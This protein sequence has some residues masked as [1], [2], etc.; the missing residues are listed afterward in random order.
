MNYERFCRR[1]VYYIEMLDQIE[2]QVTGGALRI[3]YSAL[4]LITIATVWGC[5]DKGTDPKPVTIR[6]GMRYFPVEQGNK[7]F[8]NS[9]QY[10]R[11]LS[12]DTTIAG[13]LCQRLLENGETEE[14]W[15]LTSAR[16]AQHLLAGFLWFDPPLQIPLNLEKDKPHQ[17]TAL[18]KIAPGFTSSIDSARFAGTITFTGYSQ[19]DVA[20]VA[21]DSCIGLHYIIKSTIYFH[22][23]EADT[24]TDVYD[25]Y[26]ARGIGLV[27]WTDPEEPRYLDS[28]IINGVKVP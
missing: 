27:L 10:A 2:T 18:G 11:V 22:S 20:D 13:T 25:E 1:H 17:T 14:A 24:S 5:G 19:K 6:D 15:T 12:G 9:G 8:Y 28:A 3:L 26:Y 7:W 4:F 16:F 23:A 21:V